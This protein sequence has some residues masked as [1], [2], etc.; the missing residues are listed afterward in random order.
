MKLV[1]KDCVLMNEVKCILV[2]DQINVFLKT[3]LL[4]PESSCRCI[5]MFLPQKSLRNRIIS[6]KQI[7]KAT[8]NYKNRR[9]LNSYLTGLSCLIS[10]SV[11]SPSSGFGKSSILPLSLRYSSASSFN[12][13][14]RGGGLIGRLSPW[15]IF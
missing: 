5:F 7:F 8:E 1:N 3:G 13:C 15:G 4:F 9:P 12:N 10:I 14:L 6:F 2:P 11:C